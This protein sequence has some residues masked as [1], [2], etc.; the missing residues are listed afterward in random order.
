MSTKKTP[1]TKVAT[2][3][4]TKASSKVASKTAMKKKPAVKYD[5]TIRRTQ[6]AKFIQE[7]CKAGMFSILAT[8]KGGKETLFTGRLT[9]P[10]AAPSK[11]TRPVPNVASVGMLRIYDVPKKGWRTVDLRTATQLK[12]NKK[13][14]KIS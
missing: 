12:A 14:Y 1:A 4:A 7:N 8:T 13:V 11:G 2:K 9:A 6:L 3:A 10:K 5:G